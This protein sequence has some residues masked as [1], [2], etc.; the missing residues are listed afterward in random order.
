M[1]VKRLIVLL[2][3]NH[4]QM[5][6]CCQKHFEDIISSKRG[7]NI[8]NLNYYINELADQYMEKAI[9]SYSRV[10]LPSLKK[11]D[12]DKNNMVKILCRSKDKTAPYP[13]KEAMFFEAWQKT[14]VRYD[15]EGKKRHF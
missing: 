9:P 10:Y 6:L 13:I 5:K 14:G 4:E 8:N 2:A 11:M 15:T 7:V 12:Y 1:K 3:V